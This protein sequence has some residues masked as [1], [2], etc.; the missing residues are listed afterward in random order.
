MIKN[1]ALITILSIGAIAACTPQ[2]EQ[3]VVAAI[4]PTGACIADIVMATQGTEDIASILSVCPVAVND[5]YQVVS[6][7]LA[8]EPADAGTALTPDLRA[9]LTRIQN[10]ARTLLDAGSA[11]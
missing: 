8:R 4:Q 3:Q 10:N 11:N 9:H 6:E 1:I 7:L 2:E 5:I